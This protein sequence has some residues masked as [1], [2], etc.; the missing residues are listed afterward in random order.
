MMVKHSKMNAFPIRDPAQVVLFMDRL[1]I[2]AIALINSFHAHLLVFRHRC[3][4]LVALG[5]IQ[6][7]VSAWFTH[8]QPYSVWS[9]LIPFPGLSISLKMVR[10]HG[11]S[12]HGGTSGN[13]GCASQSA[14]QNIVPLASASPSSPLSDHGRPFPHNSF[15]TTHFK[16]H[17][18][19]NKP[20]Y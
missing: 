6:N 11:V 19:L 9:C 18:W 13:H 1:L 16:F 7:L 15:Q 20:L 14:P 10:C 5:F 17:S 12:R 2:F 3:F 8:S 4:T